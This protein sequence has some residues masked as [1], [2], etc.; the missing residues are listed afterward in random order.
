MTGV[1]LTGA[2]LNRDGGFDS[3]HH[4]QMICNAGMIPNVKDNPRPRQTTKRGRERFF[5]EAIHA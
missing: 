4:R 1:V 3:K 5:N 2:Y